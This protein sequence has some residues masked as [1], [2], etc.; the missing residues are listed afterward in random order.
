VVG[1]DQA[2]AE[3]LVTWQIIEGDALRELP[4][5][6]ERSVD[7]ILADPPYS[8]GG[9]FRGDRAAGTGRKYVQSEVLARRAAG[10]AEDQP[11]FE[12]DTRDQRS[13]TLWST[14]WMLEA[15]RVLKPGAVLAVFTDWRQLPATTDAMQVA[16]FAW[17]GVVVWDKTEGVRPHQGR[18]RA[19]CEYVVWGS[20]R[21]LDETRQEWAGISAGVVRC[22]EDPPL[23]MPQLIRC[24]IDRVDKW[25]QAGKPLAML[26]ELVGWVCPPGGVLLDPFA[27][28]ASAGVVALRR[29]RSYIGIEKAPNWAAFSRERLAAEASGVSLRDAR[30]GQV[31]IFA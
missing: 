23:D 7:G 17:R 30:G 29:G 24:P 12:G 31:G 1:T 9:A 8:S 4:R 25:H 19:Q 3:D 6:E 10:E 27:G 5:L 14:A 26:A 22:P 13:F 28:S 2:T 18:P 21:A 15:E 11:D 16:G 20:R